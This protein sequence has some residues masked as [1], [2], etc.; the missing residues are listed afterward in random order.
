MTFQI[1][2]SQNVK[3][4][5]DADLTISFGRDSPLFAPPSRLVIIIASEQISAYPPIGVYC[6]FTV[7]LWMAG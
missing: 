1:E 2:Y 4:E 5:A 7:I 6:T 3:S